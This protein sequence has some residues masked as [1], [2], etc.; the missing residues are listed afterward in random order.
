METKNEP[1]PNDKNKAGDSSTGAASSPVPSKEILAI[2]S[3]ADIYSVLPGAKL[4]DLTLP[5]FIPPGDVPIGSAL[6]G[7]VL[8]IVG[9]FTGDPDMADCKN[10]VMQIP[11]RPEDKGKPKK[12]MFPITGEL[13]Q[14]LLRIPGS[15]AGLSGKILAIKRCPDRQSKKFKTNIQY[16]F[17]TSLVELLEAQRQAIFPPITNQG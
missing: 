10:L 15:G 2:L 3:P 4:T 7:M 11:L 12:I 14:S 6:I 16:H 5:D 9:D 13:G 8:E 17:E 1:K